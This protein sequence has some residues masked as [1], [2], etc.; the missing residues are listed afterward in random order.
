MPSPKKYV[1][2]NM[3]EPALHFLAALKRFD[4]FAQLG[5]KIARARTQDLPIVYAQVLPGLDLLICKVRGVQ[6]PYPDD[7][8]LLRACQESIANAL[9]Q[10][11]CGL[12]QG[13]YWYESG[14]LGFLIFA[15]RA[16]ET[17][18]AEFGGSGPPLRA[19]D[20]FRNAR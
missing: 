19:G 5:A 4:S 9:E 8:V 14:G 18:L 2:V 20:I 6:P 12:E 13:G 3:T 17:V 15:S 16:R 1:N 7:S 11:A 10:S